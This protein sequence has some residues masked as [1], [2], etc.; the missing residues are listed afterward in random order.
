MSG[1]FVS[2]DVAGSALSAWRK[3]SDWAQAHPEAVPA[4]VF[5]GPAGI[6]PEVLET[7]EDGHRLLPLAH[8]LS[9]LAPEG[10]DREVALVLGL[11]ML[12]LTQG[13]ST[14]LPRMDE[15]RQEL[16]R[17]LEQLDPGH[18]ASPAVLRLFDTGKIPKGL[19]ALVAKDGG[20]P[21]LLEPDR[22]SLHRFARLEQRLG[23]ALAGHLAQKPFSGAPVA[24]A[25]AA[26][27][28]VGK[29]LGT[30]HWALDQEWALL[31]AL[32]L[33]FSVISG[34]PGT[35]K[36]TIVVSLLRIL[37]RMGVSAQRMALAAPTGKAANRIY[38]EVQKQLKEEKERA[39]KEKRTPHPADEALKDLPEPRTLHRLLGYSPSRDR[40][41][42]DDV[43]PIEADL[44]VVDECS[45][46]DL[47]L[48]ERLFRA[49]K[50][51]TGKVKRLVLLGDANQLP[52]VEAG[53]VLFHL[54]SFTQPLQ[55]PWHSWVLGKGKG[56][57][58]KPVASSEDPRAH[59][60]TTLTYS[61]RMDPNRED[62]RAI[63]EYAE[64]IR[65]EKA[66]S[67]VGT[68]PCV[69]TPKTSPAELAFSHVEH[70]AHDGSDRKPPE[71]FFERW[72]D[73]RW[74][75]HKAL[76]RKIFT[77]NEKGDLP[78]DDE[79]GLRALV[80][81]ADSQ[82]ILCLT[83]GKGLDGAERANAWFSKRR[84][85]EDE[86]E[87][88]KIH[89]RLGFMAGEPVIVTVNDYTQRLFNGYSGIV[90][91][92]KRGQEPARLR[93]VFE[94]PQGLLAYELDDLK[95]RLQHA[96]ALTVH[97]AQGSQVECAALLLPREATSPL[98]VKQLVYTAVSRASKSV[99]LVGD[100]QRVVDAVK[101]PIRRFSAVL[102]R[103]KAAAPAV[104]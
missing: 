81:A 4:P 30:M 36:T 8:E 38:E 51:E 7:L 5:P 69:L 43:N 22:L 42:L 37:A 98:L 50:P 19:A 31:N 21:L 53:M 65:E 102:D 101:R 34:G 45:M 29:G 64:A 17:L 48:M 12:L 95:G 14:T 52:S 75:A 104:D 18:R 85:R 78:K 35:G 2:L 56:T 94:Q 84:R 62:G 47:F 13:G 87:Q 44:V 88:R 15:G 26:F 76:R 91:W 32:H 39:K 24:G 100:I 70:L 73:R 16:V 77:F 1:S 20:A 61:H 58:S 89:S 41:G 46:V 99:V 49:F 93:A 66:A 82:R 90:V 80:Q 9:R 103:A 68:G 10:Q 63:F 25:R 3:R 67:F 60:L 40:F 54:A 23:E 83:R 96:Y 27:E 72:W 28:E 92:T 74:S 59:Y 33:P 57:L 55:R 86:A 11:S 97:K 71:A 6:P 79:T